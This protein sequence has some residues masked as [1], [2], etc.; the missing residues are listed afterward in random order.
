M[1]HLAPVVQTRA[2]APVVPTR[3]SEEMERFQ[4]FSTPLPMGLAALTA[5]QITPRDLVLEPSAGTGLLTILA[6][7][8]GGSLALNELARTRA[9]LLRRLFPGRP[10]TAFDAAQI[11]DHLDEGLRPSVILMN[12]PFSA[13][14]HVG[15]RTTEATARHLRSALARLAPGGRLVAITGAGFAP[16]APAW[17]ET[18]A[19]LTERAHL[20]FTG[21]VS[22]AAFAKHGTSFET[23]ISVF[24]KCRGGEPGGITA[25]LA[26][27]ISP[28]VARLLSL[29]TAHV[30]PRLELAQVAPA[31]QGPTSPFP[32]NPGVAPVARHGRKP[33]RAV[34][35][36]R[37]GEGPAQ[38]RWL[39]LGDYR[40]EAT[41]VLPDGSEWHYGAGAP[42]C[43]CAGHWPTCT[44]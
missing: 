15:S 36:H 35:V 24:D 7:I 29:I 31:G 9:D 20:V 18:F 27:P 11:D 41:A 38:G 17:A 21:A 6:E 3:R 2:L 26:R 28:D 1:T 43:A 22:G 13:V 5:A 37:S 42:A 16:D 30:P 14:A 8:A 4:Q 10:V 40:L 23:R 33:D 25:D 39:L 34:R 32:G 19:R 44:Q 12:P